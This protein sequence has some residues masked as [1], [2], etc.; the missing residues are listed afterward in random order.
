[1]TNEV[2]NQIIGNK[3]IE[4]YLDISERMLNE[5]QLT[6]PEN[7]QYRDPVNKEMIKE[8]FHTLIKFIGNYV[9]ESEKSLLDEAK[10][11]GESVGFMSVQAGGSLEDTLSNMTLYKKS[12][13]IFIQEEGSKSG[14]HS[15]NLTEIFICIDEIFNIIVYGFSHA[16]TV[17][18]EQKLLETRTSFIRLSIPIVPLFKGMGILPLVGDID[19]LRASI[20]IE[21]TLQ[22]S[23][24][25]SINKLI[26]DFSGVYKLDESVVHT[27]DLLIRSLKLIGITPV[28]TGLRPELSLQFIS[29]G[30][31][32]TDIQITGTIEQILQEGQISI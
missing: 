30:V 26:I 24:N 21:E 17:A 9:K 31:S 10:N 32:L 12:L 29:T 11:W 6:Y 23:K 14:I 28:I 19:E 13:W 25:L 16:Y 7:P 8:V 15:K 2:H 27:L 5:I 3:L 1:M 4:S 22:K 18:T 20:L